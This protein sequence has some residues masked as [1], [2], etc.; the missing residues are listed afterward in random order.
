MS[1]LALVVALLSLSS[2]CLVAQ[3]V[4]LVPGSKVR[5]EA[6]GSLSDRVEGLLVSRTADS[7]VIVREGT[8]Y[9][10][11]LDKVSSLDIYRGK[12]RWAGARRGALWG[13]GIGLAWGILAT[14]T[15]LDEP[16]CPTAEPCGEAPPAGETIAATT[17]AGLFWGAVI[18]AWIGRK[19]WES[20]PGVGHMTVAPSTG[21]LRVGARWSW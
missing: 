16:I 18:G 3:A 20:L 14:A 4:E 1:R 21:G 17:G 19:R 11:P 9:R 7:V 6:P 2:T 13:T 8:I 15:G 12:D 5:V 10:I